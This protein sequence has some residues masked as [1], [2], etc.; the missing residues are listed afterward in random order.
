MK[1][2]YLCTVLIFTMIFSA[3]CQTEDNAAENNLNNESNEAGENADN[4]AEDNSAD[5]NNE[6]GN[7]DVNN[8]PAE[9]LP[10]EVEDAR[11]ENISLEEKPERVISILPSNTEIIYALDAWDQLVAV[12]SNDDYPPEAGDLPTV[13]DMVIDV[14]A[15]LEQEPDIVLAG[16]INDLDAVG[17]IEDAGIPVFV[18]EDPND[19][20]GV[21][22][23]IEDIGLLL[24][25]QE[26]A[27]EIVNDMEERLNAVKETGESISEED[28]VSVWVEVSPSPDIFTTGS[29]TF[30]D[31][32]LTIIGAENVAGEEDGWVAYTEEDAVL[33]NPDVIITT[34]GSYTENSKEQILERSAWQ[35][36]SAVQNERVYDIEA[37]LVSRQGPRL[38]EGVEQLA[39]LVYPEYY[40]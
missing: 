12:T 5:E 35:D 38:I 26:N 9:E 8:E 32:I 6:A 22:E 37:N 4:G 2:W 15:V 25:Q 16:L 31:E 3:A 36:V 13:G 18:A 19:F 14:E 34:Y 10:A 28:R 20:P 24:G 30:M 17:Q 39:E 23:L 7:N 27:A 29:G 33:A 1:K 21:Y 40:E 11:G